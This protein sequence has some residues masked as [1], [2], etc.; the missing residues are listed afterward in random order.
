MGASRGGTVG[1]LGVVPT[2]VA[3]AAVVSNAAVLRLAAG[4]AAAAVDPDVEFVSFV[5]GSDVAERGAAYL[6]DAGGNE[7]EEDEARAGTAAV[8]RRQLKSR[9]THPT[10]ARSGSGSGGVEEVEGRGDGSRVKASRPDAVGVVRPASAAG[11]DARDPRGGP[12]ATAA[13]SS[14]ADCS[15]R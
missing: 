4:A 15:F 11:A 14:S 5:C 9:P 2:A 7:V 6:S 10:G 13:E 8:G 1:A 12:P 3:V